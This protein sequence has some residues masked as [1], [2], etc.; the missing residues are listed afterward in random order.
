MSDIKIDNMPK[1]LKENMTCTVWIEELEG[2]R[3]FEYFPDLLV[4]EL[5]YEWFFEHWRDSV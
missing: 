2:M 5:N 1:L 3:G 4:C